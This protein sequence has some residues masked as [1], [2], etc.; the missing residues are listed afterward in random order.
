MKKPALD[1]KQVKQK[2]QLKIVHKLCMELL[3]EKYLIE[4]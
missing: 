4:K 2:D 3:Y 1:Q